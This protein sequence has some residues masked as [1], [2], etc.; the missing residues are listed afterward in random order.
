M[1][2]SKSSLRSVTLEAEFFFTWVIE[3]TSYTI[4][5]FSLQESKPPKW[6]WSCQ[7]FLFRTTPHGV[8]LTDP[9]LREP[10]LGGK[11]DRVKENWS[12]SPIFGIWKKLTTH[13]VPSLF[14]ESL[15]TTSCIPLPQDSGYDLLENKNR[16]Q[17]KKGRWAPC[18]SEYFACGHVFQPDTSTSHPPLVF[19]TGQQ[20]PPSHLWMN[21]PCSVWLSVFHLRIHTNIVVDITR[22]LEDMYARRI[23]TATVSPVPYLMCMIWNWRLDWVGVQK[24]LS[25]NFAWTDRGRWPT[26]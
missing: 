23:I 25:S 22:D 7:K 17:D 2:A 24:P 16:K 11:R 12:N 1:A 4:F 19:P 9:Q 3:N 10:K 21:Q 13:C 18:D 15:A 26:F 20:D 8:D 6:R 5:V 14:L